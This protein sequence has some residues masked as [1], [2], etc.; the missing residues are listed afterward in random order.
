MEDGVDI[1][2][3]RKSLNMT[4]KAFADY[5]GVTDR[6]VQKWEA[7]S[8]MPP[9]VIKFFKQMKNENDSGFAS[10]SELKSA[11]VDE[12]SD[13]TL[14]P[15]IHI[16]SVG[17][18][19]SDN[20]IV[21]EPEY[22]EGYVPFV[23]ARSDDRAIYQSGDSMTPTI[24]PGSIMLVRQVRDWRE[25]FGYGNIFV[26]ELRDGRRITKEVRRYDEDPKNYVTC[27]S[28]NPN[29]ADEELPKSMIFGVWK[30]VKIQID[31]GW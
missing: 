22:V 9:L 4:Q 1:K 31:K 17:G 15:L 23:G 24:P 2:K 30:V 12:S 6:T 7:G 5:C 25:Y 8:S 28:H 19:H 16:D 13:Y 18:M 27:V 21:D 29:V 26:L 14:V 3:L 20:A 10:K 11:S